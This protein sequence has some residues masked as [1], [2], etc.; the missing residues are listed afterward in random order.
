MHTKI[1][2]CGIEIYENLF[3]GARATA[4]D[5]I[6]FEQS[7]LAQFQTGLLIFK[8]AESGI[9]GSKKEV[10]KLPIYT[11]FEALAYLNSKEKCNEIKFS[12]NGK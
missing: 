10:E 2:D 3:I 9:Y 8:V 1:A 4:K 12:N 5:E 6:A 7:G 11:F